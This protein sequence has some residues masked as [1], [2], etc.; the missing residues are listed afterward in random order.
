MRSRCSKPGTCRI[1]AWLLFPTSGAYSATHSCANIS[2]LRTCECLRSRLPPLT[3]KIRQSSLFQSGMERCFIFSHFLIPYVPSRPA[4][5]LFFSP[6]RLFHTSV[7]I[8]LSAVNRFRS[9]SETLSCGAPPVP[10]SK[11]ANVNDTGGVGAT[12]FQESGGYF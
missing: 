11:V 7:Y 4:R 3:D 1:T 12:P 8:F 2:D 9:T 6:V 5:L 10:S